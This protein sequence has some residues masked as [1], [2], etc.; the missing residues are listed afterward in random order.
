MAIFIIGAN[1]INSERY[2]RLYNSKV[3]D[4]AVRNIAEKDLIYMMRSNPNFKIQNADYRDGKIVGSTGSL[5]KIENQICITV[6]GAINEN[7]SLAGYK[8]V[9][10]TGRVYN[11]RTEDALHFLT[12]KPI[13]NASVVNGSYLRG[14]NWEIPVIEDKEKVRNKESKKKPAYLHVDLNMMN[15]KYSNLY[16]HCK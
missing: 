12:D 9:D 5:E 8:F 15:Y 2:F 13:Q 6:I 11:M 1:K 3:E 4:N 10:T 14:I 7:N 16:F